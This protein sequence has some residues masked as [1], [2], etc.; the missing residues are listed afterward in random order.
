MEATTMRDDAQSLLAAAKE[1]PSELL[2][3]LLGEIEVVRC[4]A[5]ARLTTPA[6]VSG[7]DELLEVEEAARRLTVTVD[8]LY[9]HSDD[10]AFT[11]RIANKVRF[12]ALGIDEWIRGQGGLTA[13]PVV[14][15]KVRG[16]SR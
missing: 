16:K 4:T 5:M 12:S 6:Q 7:P 15:P 3:M 10:Y 2:P 1:M 8:H 9:R 11:R 14:K 13:R